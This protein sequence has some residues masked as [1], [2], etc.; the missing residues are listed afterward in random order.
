MMRS[1]AQV[2]QRSFNPPQ[3]HTQAHT[4]HSTPTTSKNIP[5]IMRKWSLN[6]LVDYKRRPTRVHFFARSS[7]TLPQSSNEHTLREREAMMWAGVYACVCVCVCV[8]ICVWLY[9]C[10]CV[11]VHVCICVY[12]CICVY[13]CV[14]SFLYI[15]SRTHSLA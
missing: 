15:C 1:P 4:A 5:H 2:V 10:V 9:V 6:G 11:C 12:R 13:L 8:C 14:H 3:I 7:P